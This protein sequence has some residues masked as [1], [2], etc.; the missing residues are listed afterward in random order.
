MLACPCSVDLGRD[1]TWLMRESGGDVALLGVWNGTKG[2]FY[3]AR[4]SQPKH[5]VVLDT[6]GGARRSEPC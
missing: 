6:E 5:S 3:K 1:L 4:G 2:A